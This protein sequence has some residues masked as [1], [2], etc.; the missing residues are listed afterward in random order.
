MLTGDMNILA[1]EFI[2][3]YKIKE[4]ARSTS[5]MWPTFDDTIGK[6]AEASMREVDRQEQDR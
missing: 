6:A 1:I 4:F 5:S 2:V 3:Q